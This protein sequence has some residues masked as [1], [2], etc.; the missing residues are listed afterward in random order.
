[1]SRAKWI[2]AGV[3]LALVLL[4]LWAVRDTGQRTGYVAHAEKLFPDLPAQTATVRRIEIRSAGQQV[5]LQGAGSDWTVVEKHGFAADP[6]KVRALLEGLAG[7]TLIESRTADPARHAALNLDTPDTAGARGALVRV[8]GENDTVLA[9]VLLGKPRTSAGQGPRQM[10]VRRPAEDQTWLAEGAVDP[11]R[12]PPLWLRGEAFDLPQDSVRQVSVQHPGQPPLVVARSQ[13]ED[14]F[15]L[16][17]VPAGRN[18]RASGVGAIAYGLQRLPMQN[19]FRVDEVAGDWAQ[20]TNSVFETFDGL[21]VTATVLSLNGV[22]HVRLVA[23]VA[24]SASDEQRTAAAGKA[25]RLNQQLAD[26]VFLIP[27]HT[28]ATFTPKLDDLLEP[29]APPAEAT[30]SG[31]AVPGMPGMMPG[32]RLPGM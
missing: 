16:A 3:T 31:P 13:A 18:I 7:L 29:L 20:A 27:P 22:P 6:A 19:V 1:M 28:A 21:V 10:F 24:A 32:T 17:Q 15:T 2:L 11:Q 30:P 12:T 4:T 26:W 25:E 14:A 5:T 8:L 23:T 9:A